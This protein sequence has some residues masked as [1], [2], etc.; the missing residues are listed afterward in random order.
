MVAKP[1]GSGRCLSGITLAPGTDPGALDVQ[2]RALRVQISE[3]TTDFFS[4]AT[5]D[6]SEP[7]VT[8]GR[9]GAEDGYLWTFLRRQGGQWHATAID[10][11]IVG[12]GDT[13][14]EAFHSLQAMVDEYLACCEREGLSPEEAMRPL[15]PRWAASMLADGLRRAARLA[16]R[17]R[18]GH[19]GQILLP[20]HGC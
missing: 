8:G 12:S 9:D 3:T 6:I 1:W 13:P 5:A 20:R 2:D 11:S 15:P 19:S 10:Y 14:E 4:M 16:L 7:P 17:R 18:R